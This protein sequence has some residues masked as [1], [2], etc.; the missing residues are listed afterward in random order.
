MAEHT[1]GETVGATVAQ[2]SLEQARGIWLRFV[3]EWGG[4]PAVST[5]WDLENN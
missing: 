1:S 3:T 2:Q 4:D 5:W